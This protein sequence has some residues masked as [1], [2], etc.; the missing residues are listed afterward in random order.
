MKNSKFMASASLALNK[1]RFQCK[2]HSPEI[3]VAVGIVGT[4]VSTVLACKATTKVSEILDTTKKDID[5]V[6]K[7]TDNKELA[8]AYT[9]DD[10]KKDLAIIY[11]QTGVKLVKLYGP[12]FAVGMASVT[13]ILASHKIMRERNVALAAAYATIDKGFKDYRSRVVDR[14][15]EQVDRE[16]KYNIKAKKFE[17]TVVD[18]E[19]GKEKKVKSMV[20]VSDGPNPESDYARIFDKSCEGWEPESDYNLMFLR[21]QQSYANDLLKSRG[22]VFL[23][24]VYD[25]LGIKR[26]TAGQIVGWKYDPKNSD[27]DNFVDF[28]ISEMNRETE[29]GYERVILLDFNVDGAI[30]E[31]I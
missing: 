8:E 30:A 27:V 3:L 7:A 9:K 12:A 19:T 17:E 2:Q 21:A 18:E 10:A 20:A 24:E 31:S 6:H 5:S 15:G 16:L 1:A 28:G 26:T 11:A 23:N 14:F 13:S 22:H 25:M 29:S 4:V